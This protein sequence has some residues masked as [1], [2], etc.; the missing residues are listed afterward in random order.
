VGGEEVP[1]HSFLISVLYEEERSVNLPSLAALFTQ[2]NV[3]KESWLDPR[4]GLDFEEDVNLFPILVIEARMLQL[5]PSH[6][7]Y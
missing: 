5:F 2:G 3:L 1:L 7:I 6:Y 4:L